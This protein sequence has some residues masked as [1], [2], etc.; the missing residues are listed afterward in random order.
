MRNIELPLAIPMSQLPMRM[1]LKRALT[2]DELLRFCERQEALHV[3]REPNGELEVTFV[4]GML[5]SAAASDV[6]G[7]L[8]NWSERG[9]NGRVLSNCGYCLPDGSMRGPRISWLSPDTW[10]AVK[11][12]GETGFI[13]GR[14]DFLVEVISMSRTRREWQSRM[15]TWTSNGVPLAW[16][17]DPERKCVEV[18]RP[19][20][21][22]EIQQGDAIVTGEGPVTGFALELGRVWS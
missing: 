14:P 4:G 6:L 22:P 13:H 8:G 19:I 11:D 3:E 2:D 18:Y 1:R 20:M 10:H 15:K 7:E 17:V 12:H 9:Q 16:L 21:D 5:A